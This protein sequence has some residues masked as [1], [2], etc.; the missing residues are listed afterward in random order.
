MKLKNVG[1]NKKE[2]NPNSIKNKEVECRYCHVIGHIKSK[3][4]KLLS[5][6]QAQ[7]GNQVQHVHANVTQQPPKY[8]KPLLVV[9]TVSKKDDFPT[10]GAPRNFN[11]TTTLNFAS[12]MKK[13]EEIQT[14]D[15]Q[16]AENEVII[17]GHVMEISK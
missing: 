10:L 2:M 17:N 6:A 13:K 16:L 4:P 5:R 14:T 3:C 9:N 11:Q 12:I 15:N 7:N 8:T 1:Y